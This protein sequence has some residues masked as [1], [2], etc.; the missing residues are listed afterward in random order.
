MTAII[1]TFDYASFIVSYPAFSN[2]SVFPQATLQG[3]WDSG[4]A[5]I[6]NVDYGWL[7][8][9]ARQQA[10]NLMTAHIAALF[11]L[12]AAGQVPGL[13]Q[14][15]TIDKITVGLTPPPLKNQF[16]WWLSLTPYGQ[17]LLALLQVNSVGGFFVGSLPERTAF[18]SVGG[19][20]PP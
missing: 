1:L 7:N 19:I 9:A 12:I 14:T 13:M 2:S 6:S 8:G 20:F 10:L 3:Y 18:R 11:V 15:A 16:Q 4:T 17:M 5:Y